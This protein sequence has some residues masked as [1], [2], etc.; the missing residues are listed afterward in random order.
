M[1]RCA[2]YA[3]VCVALCALAA[4]AGARTGAKGGAKVQAGIKKQAFGKTSDGTAVDLYTLTNTKGMTAKITNYGG[5]VTELHAPD[6]DGK[7]ENVVL[8]FDNL[9]GYLKGHPYFGAICGRVAN[10]IAGARFTLDGKEYKLAANNGPHSLHGG[11]KGFDKVVWKAEPQDTSDGPALKL[12][13]VSPEGEEGFPGKLT[14]IVTYTLTS[15]NELKIDYKAT[16]DKA[17]PVNLTH[18]GYFNL[19]GPKDETILGHEMLIVADSYTP[20]DEKLIPTG[21][22]ERVKGTP[23][24]FTRFT[25]IGARIKQIKS[26]P[27]GYDHNYV[28]GTQGKGAVLAAQVREPKTGRLMEVFTTEPAIQLYTGNFLDGKQTG[29]GGIT[30]R[31]HY[32]FCLEA[33]HYPDSVHHNN[34]P[35]IILRPGQTY[36]QTT[37]YRFSAK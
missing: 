21:T 3:G 17:T 35:S 14:T 7:F 1:R 9:A 6:R 28:L 8:G 11:T 32:G 34:F 5:I 22:I 31:Q 10:R 12:T 15:N 2:M 19:L 16:T 4:L 33:Q 20:T 26:D 13:Y 25:P 36:T 30:Y 23:L 24:D 18:H 29:Q 27:V 37:V